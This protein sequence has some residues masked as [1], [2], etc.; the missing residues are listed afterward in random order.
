LRALFDRSWPR[1]L[2]AVLLAATTVLQLAIHFSVP[3]PLRQVGLSPAMLIATIYVQNLLLPL[4]GL[5]LASQLTAG[6][7]D[8][9]L[10]GIWPRRAMLLVPLAFGALFLASLRADRGHSF[11]M[12]AGGTIMMILSYV[13]SLGDKSVLLYP[14]IGG[15]YAFAPA[16]LFS[17]ALLGVFARGGTFARCCAGIVLSTCFIVGCGDYRHVPEMMKHG[18]SWPEQVAAW[19]LDSSRPL[20]IWPS[21]WEMKLVPRGS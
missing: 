4:T 12:V 17:L 14:G 15:R 13:G 3:I 5:D 19:R 7:R 18:P 21:G 10:A 16:V 20:Q 9:L 11:W 1:T 8:A 2:Q 6:Y